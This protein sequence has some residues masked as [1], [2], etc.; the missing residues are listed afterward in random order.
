MDYDYIIVGGGSAGSVLAGR[1][2][3]DSGTRVLLL[4]AGPATG[5]AA[6]ADPPAWLGLLGSEVDWGYRTTPQRNTNGTEHFWP[7][8]KVLGGSS[9]I[10]AMAFV[11]GDR[12]PYDAWQASGATGWGYD[13][14]LPYF[15]RSESAAGRDPAVR[16]TDGPLQVAP[17]KRRH[18]LAQA[19][20]DAVLEA[21]HPGSDD[22]S[23]AQPEGAGWYDTNIVDGA[24]QSAAD[25][26]LCPYLERPNLT[27]VTEAL[28]QRLVMDGTRCTG[29]RYE[30]AAG[31]QLAHAD[32]EVVLSAGT[33]GSAQLLLLSGI[34]PADHL[35]ELGIEVL[36]DLPGVGENLQDHVQVPL[37]YRSSQPV[38]PG[39]NNHGEMLA[40][41]RSTPQ[42]TEPD[43]MVYPVDMPYAPGADDLPGQG[44]TVMSVLARPHSRGT[45]RL[46]STDPGH[47]PLLDPNYLGDDRDMDT[48]L[49]ALRVTR[50]I[51]EAPALAPWRAQEAVPGPDTTSDEA[52][53]EHIRRTTG[54]EWHPAGTCKMGTDAL[55]VVDPE[56][57]V[58]GIAGLRVADASVMP[59]VPSTNIN[60]AVIAIAERAAELISRSP[61][62]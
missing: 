32:R 47:P 9:S 60:A 40:L 39:E 2:S 29:V 61:A 36:A 19:V 23:G 33:I 56:L 52:L 24:R 12:A 27:V 49:A 38:H 4:E 20:F 41:L 35:R 37:V 17:V 18:P 3:Q 59:V 21:G 8:G 10:N 57:R 6:M 62:S 48:L 7:R 45:L 53:R 30:T 54:T 44:Y 14:L 25:A 16:G 34:G 55:A 26:Y 11:R 46:A 42:A 28:V 50:R 51:G 15:K 1:L 13:D 58:R 5:P 31:T 22:P 43:M